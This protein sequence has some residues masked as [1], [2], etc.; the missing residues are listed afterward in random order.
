[1]LSRVLVWTAEDEVVGVVEESFVNTEKK[2]D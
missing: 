1:M 2:Y